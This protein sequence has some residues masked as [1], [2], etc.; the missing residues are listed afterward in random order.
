[1]YCNIFYIHIDLHIH[2]MKSLHGPGPDPGPRRGPTAWPVGGIWLK[3]LQIKARLLPFVSLLPVLPPT[4]PRLEYLR[5][6][7]GNKYL[8]P[9]VI[10]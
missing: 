6:V 5:I 4:S 8:I 10:G 3:V 7:H 9:A 1:M 2:L